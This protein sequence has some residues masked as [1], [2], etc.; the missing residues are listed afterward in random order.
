MAC[1]S[2]DAFAP[3]T[4]HHLTSTVTRTE[5]HAKAH[6]TRRAEIGVEIACFVV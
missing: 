1:L 3:G 2:A 6:L 5:S 4:T